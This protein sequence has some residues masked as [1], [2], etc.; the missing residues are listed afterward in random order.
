MKL[1]LKNIIIPLGLVPAFATPSLLISCSNSKQ[2]KTNYDFGLASAPLNSLNYVTFKDTTKVV[3]SMVEG[4]IKTGTANKIIQS[5]LTFPKL[6]ARIVSEVTPGDSSLGRLSSNYYGLMDN[7]GYLPGS[8]ISSVEGNPLTLLKKSESSSTYLASA[9]QLGKKHKWSNGD[10]VT[11]HDYI[12][13]FKYILDINT[14][15]QFITDVQETSI[16]NATLIV[17]KQ[18]EY[19]KKWKVPYKDPFGYVNGWESQNTGDENEVKEIREAALGFGV[20]TKEDY[21]KLAKDIKDSPNDYTNS[22]TP[23]GAKTSI[24]D[25]IDPVGWFDSQQVVDDSETLFIQYES[26]RPQT[27]GTIVSDITRRNYFMPINRKFVESNGGIQKFG[28]DKEHFLWNSAFKPTDMYLGPAGYINLEKDQ[29]YYNASRTISNKVK[30]F[31]QSDPMVLA[32]MFEDGYIGQ[33]TIPATYQKIFWSDLSK[34]PYMNKNNGFG[35]QAFSLNLDTGNEAL[36]DDNLRKA[37]AFAIDRNAMTKIA[38]QE[39]SFP[40]T[41]WTAFGQAIDDFGIPIE[42]YFD[43]E[44]YVPYKGAKTSD[45]KD[46]ELPIQSLPYT[47]HNAKANNFEQVDRT[48]IGYNVEIAN[49]FLDEFKKKNPTK[50]SVTLK[51]VYDGQSVNKNIGV[52]LES[53]L[54][55]AF[56]GY[57]KLD[58]Q[59]L[60]SNVFESARTSGNYDILFFNYDSYGTEKDSYIKRFFMPD[61]IN[62]DEQKTSGFRENPSGSFTYGEWFASKKPDELKD[63][64]TR[65]QILDNYSLIDDKTNATLTVSIWDK[66]LELST[67]KSNEDLS[68]YKKRLDNFF[69]GNIGKISKPEDAVWGEQKAIILVVAA[70]EKIVREAMPVIPLMEVDTNWEAKT[71]AGLD[72]VSTFSLQTAYSVI[73]NRP[74]NLPGVE[75]IKG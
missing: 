6:N 37:I 24:D 5:A 75:A 56:G 32:S 15:S 48:D 71:I 57:I 62:E 55:Q 43:T 16:K 33:L 14:G 47:Y 9:V 12:D 30:I 58:I 49:H 31:F 27:F 29:L 52:F 21:K 45:G 20:F 34:R 69:T 59:G 13:T 4:L 42:T 40:V 65:L 1:K 53:L 8:S 50:K 18:N 66:V 60:P 64:K 11:A 7:W 72:S 22:V 68:D 2:V 74:A 38:A 67:R 26:S 51:Y 25:F 23:A 41:T 17:A 44:K 3:S 35:T 19:I 61:E 39:A 10:T 63:I 73:K 28:I 46:L 54:K 36:K 70:F